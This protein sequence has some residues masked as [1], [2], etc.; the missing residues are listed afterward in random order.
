MENRKITGNMSTI[1]MCMEMSEGNPGAIQVISQM[2]Y[3]PRNFMDIFLCDSLNIRGSKLY[4][5]NS[6]CCGRNFD[7]FSRTLKMFRYGVYSLEEIHGNLDLVRA[8]PFIDDSIVIE[9]VPPYGKDFGPSNDKWKEYCQKNKESF[10]K[11]FKEAL[12]H[13]DGPR[14]M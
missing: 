1:D 4:M 10:D 7:K 2:M 14:K 3:D 11:R 5:L 12:E 9:G 6:D 13:D 8:I